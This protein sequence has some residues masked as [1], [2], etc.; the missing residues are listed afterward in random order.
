MASTDCNSR[1]YV[2]SYF[3]ASVME[4]MERARA[5]LGSDALLLNTREAPP[6]ARHLGECEVV[7]GMRPPTPPAI[8]APE[9]AVDPVVDLR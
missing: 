1:L 4:A 5:E 9:A 7:F 2:K 6:E 8:G 3:A